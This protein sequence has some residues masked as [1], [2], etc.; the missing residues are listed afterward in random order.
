MR[1]KLLLR[2]RLVRT[3]LVAAYREMSEDEIREA[4]AVE[5]A[6]ATIADAAHDPW[7]APPGSFDVIGY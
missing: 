6:E 2:S 4:E 7:K 3:D 5:W 1:R